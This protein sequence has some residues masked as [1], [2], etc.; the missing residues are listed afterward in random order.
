MRKY[1]LK[2]NDARVIVIP[3]MRILA[4]DPGVSPTVCLVIVEMDRPWAVEFWEGRETSNELLSGKRKRLRPDASL[5]RM[6]LEEARPDL[7]L[8]EEVGPRPGEGASSSGALLSPPACAKR[9]PLPLAS[10]RYV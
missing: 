10:E 2:V 1:T 5:L 4:I 6:V 7:V 8:I 3:L 9:Y